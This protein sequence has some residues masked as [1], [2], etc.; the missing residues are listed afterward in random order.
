MPTTA[1]SRSPTGGAAAI[2]AP[3]ATPAAATGIAP[4]DIKRYVQ[5]YAANPLFGHHDEWVITDNPFR[6]PVDQQAVTQ[7]NFSQPLKR[8]EVF[9]SSAL[10]AQR[11]LFNVYETDL[12]FLPDKDFA[13]KRADFERFYSNENKLLG[14]LIRPTLEA[15]VFGFL[16]EEIDISGKWS[17]AAVK[18][19]LQH[20]VENHERS[21]LDIVSAVLSSPDPEKAALALLIQVA[22]DF[23]T[24]S[25]ASARNLLGKFGPVQSELFKIAIDD[26][27]YGVH[28]AK[29]STL[30]ESTMATCGLATDAHAYWHFYLTGSLALNNY[31]HYVCRDHSKFF[32]AIGAVAVGESLFAHTCRKFSEMLRAVF[33][34]RIDTYYFDEH[35][36][37]D[38]HHGRM[39]T[40]NVVA[41][42]IAKYGNSVIPEIVRGI[43]ELQSIT[44][45]A[46]TDFMAQLAWADDLQGHKAAAARARQGGLSE[47]TESTK[48]TVVLREGEPVITRASDADSL[49]LVESGTL[50]L[51]AGHGSSIQIQA[52]EGLVVRRGRLQGASSVSPECLYHVYQLKD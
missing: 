12:V 6:R 16:D 38:A 33:G 44:S 27:G 2:K 9:S 3:A 43:E 10:A 29:H 23:L 4:E 22:G 47:E 8:E 41:P 50:E 51:V 7:H 31:Y 35:F 24:E 1:E 15:H 26:Y 49:W 5:L 37:I 36:H 17:A 30:F 20:L 46:D 39:A 52:S 14:E 42:A 34:D 48:T 45:L 28:K 11:M 25:S 32:R 18:S 40:E 19:Y 13:A 21:E